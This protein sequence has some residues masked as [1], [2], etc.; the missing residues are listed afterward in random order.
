LY[1]ADGQYAHVLYHRETNGWDRWRLVTDDQNYYYRRLSV[2]EKNFALQKDWKLPGVCAL[3][4]GGGA[5]DIDF[6]PREG[7]R[8]DIAYL[9]EG[10]RYFVALTSQISPQFAWEQKIE[11]SRVADVE[12]PHICELRYDHLSR[13]A[14]LWIE[15]QLKLSGYHGYR[16]FQDDRGL[17]FG[18]AK[19][20]N[21]TTSNVVFRTVRCEAQ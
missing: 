16:Q 8:F 13:T 9:Q 2:A 19:Y 6:D 17:M 11:F 5:S 10:N 12:H 3:A 20:L 18:A 7:P 15:G 1:R 14:S 21:A 4:K